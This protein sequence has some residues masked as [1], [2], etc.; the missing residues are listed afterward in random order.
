MDPLESFNILEAY[1][2]GKI[3]QEDVD[4]TQ[5]LEV[6]LAYLKE[7]ENAIDSFQQRQIDET[8]Q[9]LMQTFT[10]TPQTEFYRDYL[11]KIEQVAS[12]ALRSPVQETE[13]RLEILRKAHEINTGKIPLVDLEDHSKEAL[14]RLA[15]YLSNVDFSN[16]DFN[17]WT[18][19]EIK[20]FIECCGNLNE[21]LI[22]TDKIE[23]LPQLPQCTGLRCRNC[24]SLTALPELLQCIG[25]YCGGCTSLT[26]LPELPKCTSL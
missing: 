22:S 1:S 5:T 11:H 26:A 18:S 10:V 9:R 8:V 14:F 13:E 20:K 7:H 24:T 6:A 16:F 2:S 17:E 3:K 15:P 19:E 23:E 12:R 21:L 4:I 25:L